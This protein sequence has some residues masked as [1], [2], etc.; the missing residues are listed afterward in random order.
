MIGKNFD[1]AIIGAGP[2]GIA[3]ATTAAKQGASTVLFDDSSSL[4]GHFYKQL[5]GDFSQIQPQHTDKD[6]LE[7]NARKLRLEHS[8]AQ[9]LNQA[10]VWGIFQGENNGFQIYAEHQE[11]ETVSTTA[12]AIILAPGVYDRPLPFLGWE[13]P[14]V[15][16]PGAMQIMIK[17]QG[18]LPGKR[19]LVCGTGPLQLI[20]AASLV[21]AGADVA[22]LLDT[23]GFLDGMFSAPLA[24]SGLQSRLGDI[25]HSFS[26]LLKKDV[27]ILFHHAVIK[28][29]GDPKNGVEKAVIG[30]ISAEGHPVPDPQQNLQVDSICCA[31]GFVPSIALTLHLGCEHVYQQNLG[32]YVP[33]YDDHMQT[34]RPG[35]YV[36]GDVTGV[37]GK[38]LADLQGKLAAISALERLDILSTE[39][40]NSQRVQLATPL[41]RQERFSRWLWNRYRIKPN[42]LNIADENTIICRCENV[43]IGDLKRSLSQSARDLYGVKLRTRLGMGSCQG[44]YCM[45]NA[46]ILIAQETG[47]PVGETGIQ[48]V[49]P[50][51]TPIRLKNI[52]SQD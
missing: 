50:P 46:A 44:R 33:R 17:K 43:T 13:L 16:T 38:P 10:R 26:T 35:I 28:A 15:M 20:V 40:A 49:R 18:L 37:G 5:P 11:C 7:L 23:C 19:V 36:A 29:L 51:I 9:V 8:Q 39:Q 31:Y 24:F 32:A 34:S 6:T 22:A 2:A 21:E 4:G 30:K 42:L 45:M 1:I 3:A 14:G 47:I 41:R 52:A 48:S 27:P 12:E 25:V